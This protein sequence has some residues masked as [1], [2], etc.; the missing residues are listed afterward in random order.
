MWSCLIIYRF[1]DKKTLGTGVA[2]S[3]A[4]K[5][6]LADVL[7][8]RIITK[9]K[10]RKAATVSFDYTRDTD[11][12]DIDLVGKFVKCDGFSFCVIDIYRK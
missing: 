3:L 8:I 11:L 4:K 9:I 1:F 6:E 2:G 12:A 5:N 7:I 10:R